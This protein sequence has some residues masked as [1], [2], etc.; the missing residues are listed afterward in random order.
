LLTRKLN[1]LLCFEFWFHMADVSGDKSLTL[2]VGFLIKNGR[3]PV[4]DSACWHSGRVSGLE[5][6]E[7]LTL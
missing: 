3:G 7:L 6:V 5:C 1:T 2:G 4:I